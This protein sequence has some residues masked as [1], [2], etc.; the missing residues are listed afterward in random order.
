MIMADLY[1]DAAASLI[2]VGPYGM[3]LERIQLITSPSSTV[4][5]PDRPPASGQQLIKITQNLPRKQTRPP[6]MQITRQSFP[7]PL[8]RIHV[9]Q[10]YPV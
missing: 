6:H 1:S 7:S 5:T 2:R 4:S 9:T 8:T 10:Q 3:N